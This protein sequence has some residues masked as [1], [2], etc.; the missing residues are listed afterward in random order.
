M[1]L[2]Y[3]PV[4]SYSQKAQIALHELDVAY[5]PM[6]TALF[7]PDVVAEYRALYPLGK[8]PLLVLDDGTQIGESTIII[9]YLNSAAGRSALIPSEASAALRTRQ[10]DRICDLYVNDPMATILFDS[11]K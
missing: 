3:H 9:E 6:L 10:L 4:S 11:W 5:T 7:R 8:V 1:K 2:Y